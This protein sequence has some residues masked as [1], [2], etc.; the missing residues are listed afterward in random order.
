MDAV[1]TTTLNNLI[2]T[3]DFWSQF[4]EDTQEYTI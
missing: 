2:Y 3:D 1:G 4:S